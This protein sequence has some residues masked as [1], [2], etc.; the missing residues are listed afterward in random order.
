MAALRAVGAPIATSVLNSNRAIQAHI[1]VMRAFTRL[2]R[3]L[4]TY[5]D[6][7]RKIEDMEAKC[8][9]QFRVVFEALRQLLET[10]EQPERRIG[11]VRKEV[12]RLGNETI[13][14]T[15]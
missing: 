4:A 14:L 5:D 12:G 3:M 6:L 7:S 2:R 10:E 15:T 8:D 11:F 1:Q 13:R 9:D